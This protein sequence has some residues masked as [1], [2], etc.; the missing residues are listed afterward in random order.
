MTQG[1]DA[2]QVERR[3]FFCD[4]AHARIQRREDGPDMIEGYAA[5]YYDPADAGT[6]YELWKGYLER[7][8]AGAFD[9]VLDND[10]RGL[11]NHDANMIL[12]RSN[13]KANTMRLSVDGRGLRYEIDIP[14]TQAGRDVATSIERG[15]VT[16]S[17][18]SFYVEEAKYTDTEDGVFIRTITKFRQ[19]FDVGPVTFPAYTAT[20]AGVRDA[21]KSTIEAEIEAMKAERAKSAK[22]DRDMVD[23]AA[24][25]VKARMAI[26]A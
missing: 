17:S 25:Y 14:D 10:V 7:I 18:F 26:N 6:E 8:E 4:L 11:F 2:L 19:L 21:L 5:V 12:G 1:K 22:T 3:T 24:G 23:V 16:G 13:G 15:D 9:A 20:E